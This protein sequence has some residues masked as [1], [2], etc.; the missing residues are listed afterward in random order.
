MSKI[1][2]IE[3]QNFMSIK[4]PARLEF[5]ESGILN[6][7]GYND[8]GKSAIT[9]A[10][11]VLFYD[12]YSSDQVNFIHDGEEYFAIG[13]EF[14]DG[15]SI[16]KYKYAN[17]KSVWEMLKGDQV[18]YTNRIAN[19]VAALNDVP[20]PIAKY[21]GVVQD[22]YTGEKLNVRRNTDRLFL[23]NTT[24][25]DNYKIIN[26]VLRCDILAEAVKRMNEDRNKL[27]SEVTNLATSHVTLKKELESI[28]VID[29]ETVKEIQTKSE[30]LRVNKQRLE[31]L[32]AIETHK[33]V[34]EDFNVYDELPLIDTTRLTDIMHIM[35]LKK[36]VDTP[37]YEE[38][39]VIDTSRLMLLEEIKQLRANLDIVIPPELNIVSTERLK[40]IRAL[41]EAYNLLWA[42]SNELE[43][44]EKEYNETVSQLQSLSQQYGFK[45]CKSCGAVVE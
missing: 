34:F 6:I 19:G 5:D 43:K 16:N 2:A 30:N 45:I 8:S 11:E 20:A 9:R 4:D 35:E 29:D 37:I 39:P 12:A 28:V 18:I 42:I 10:L 44:V 7:T 13:L 1:K 17:G 41:G 38:C 23:I 26:S 36:S 22:E 31:Y 27:Q 33:K 3:I 25:G 14:D 24:G 15:I 32:I 21:L 40:D